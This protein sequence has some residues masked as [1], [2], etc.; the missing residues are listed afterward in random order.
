[1]SQGAVVCEIWVRHK[2][3]LPGGASFTRQRPDSTA[4]RTLLG[5]FFFPAICLLFPWSLAYLKILEP[6][7]PHDV[8]QSWARQEWELRQARLPLTPT[9]CLQGFGKLLSL[10]LTAGSVRWRGNEGMGGWSGVT[11]RATHLGFPFSGLSF[12]ISKWAL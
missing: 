7:S 8:G 10:D 1:M 6:R 2:E 12:P 5:D 3:G 9:L 4:S 11:C